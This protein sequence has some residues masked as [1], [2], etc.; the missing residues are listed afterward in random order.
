MIQVQKLDDYDVTSSSHFKVRQLLSSPTLS[1]SDIELLC[2]YNK[3]TAHVRLAVD[4]SKV[5]ELL[6]PPLDK[7][8]QELMA[9]LLITVYDNRQTSQLL[10]SPRMQI[11]IGEDCKVPNLQSREVQNMNLAEFVEQVKKLLSARIR[12]VG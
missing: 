8:R 6:L 11:I 10:L 12:L 7:G 1:E 3:V 4:M 9:S 5:P 2:D